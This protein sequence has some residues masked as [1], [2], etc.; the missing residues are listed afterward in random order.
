MDKTRHTGFVDNY[1]GW[2]PPQLEKVEFLPIQLEHAAFRVGQAY[3][4]Q[5]MLS[6]ISGKSF[7]IFWANHDYLSLPF[8]KFLIILA[9]LRHLPLAEWSGKPPIKYK[10]YVRLTVEIGQADGFTL[11]I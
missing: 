11:V 1:L 5:V 8:N 2:H 7:G 10:E 4:G 3:K 6:P 9:Q